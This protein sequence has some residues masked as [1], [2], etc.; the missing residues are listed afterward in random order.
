MK[1]VILVKVGEL[2]LKG[3]NKR[4]FETQL[5]RDIKRRIKP[6]GQYDIKIAQ[7]TIS[8]ESIDNISNLDDILPIIA[9][10]SGITRFSKA[11]RTKKDIDEIKNT[12]QSDLAPILSSV[13]SFKVESKRSDKKFFMKSPQISEEIGGYI[14]DNFPNLKVDV[15]NPDVTVYIEIRDLGAYILTD[16]QK[17]I[18][19]LPSGTSGRAAVLISGGID[20]PV[21]AFMM[22]K[23]GLNLIAI[24]FASPPYTSAK[25]E[26]KVCDLL[27]KIEQYSGPI[28]LF[29]VPF[30]NIQQ[31]IRK[32]CPEELST[33]I[34]RRMMMKISQ[35]I[36]QKENCKA[37]I[38]GESLGQ[39]A[40]QTLPALCCTNEG[41]S[42]PVL[43][44]LI[45][46][47]KD[48]IIN[49]STKIGTFDISIQPFEDCCTVFTPKRPKTRPS[50]SQ[51]KD[52]EKGIDWDSLINDAVNNVKIINIGQ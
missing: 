1:E 27:E 45:G 8:L 44:P 10:V 25:A 13:S 42:M 41:L 38:T 6:F 52:A 46:M 47:D 9:K 11:F 32:N 16:S 20:S 17:G 31:Q 7:S 23:R 2:I 24:H 36:S 35:I 49:I 50:M 40:S 4:N 22:A 28:K 48:E 39:V 51:I 37:L 26:K 34:T 3:L 14:L 12:I 15:H 5:I 43:R 21:A 18:G 30:T 33:L 29:I 19:G